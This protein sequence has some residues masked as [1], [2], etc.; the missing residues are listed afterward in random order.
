MRQTS[1]RVHVWRGDPTP[2]SGLLRRYY[3]ED[4]SYYEGLEAHFDPQTSWVQ[5]VVLPLCQKASRV[6][7]AGCGSGSLVRYLATLF[8][9]RIF[10]GVDLSPLGI[11]IGHRQAAALK[12]CFL[13][14]GD[15]LHLPFPNGSFDLVLSYH[16]LEHTLEPQG[17]LAEA[18]CVL[19]PQGQLY[20]NYANVLLHGS[21]GLYFREMIS[22][23]PLLWNR[24]VLTFLEPQLCCTACG[25]RDAVWVASP[26]KV[27]RLLD[28]VG[29]RIEARH[30]VT[31]WT[32][33]KGEERAQSRL[34]RPPFTAKDAKRKGETS[35]ISCLTLSKSYRQL[36]EPHGVPE[37]VSQ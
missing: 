9:E 31:H 17:L 26:W 11:A 36:P 28:R 1:L 10:F 5:S 35:S 21:P 13:S 33:R 25:D 29:L 6:L 7:D 37:D 27:E 23:V 12:N 16:V 34:K 2:L 30:G 19:A 22:T 20:L 8:P 4:T 3:H 14:V 18:A 24:L 15:A 32:V